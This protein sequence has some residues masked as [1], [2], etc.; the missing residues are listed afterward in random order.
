MLNRREALESA[1]SEKDAHLAILEITG[2][3]TAKQAEEEER[4]K[5]DR[6]RL[7]ERLRQEVCNKNCVISVLLL[8]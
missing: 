3:R 6:R 4:L 5:K 1:I 2:I 7:V 8:N